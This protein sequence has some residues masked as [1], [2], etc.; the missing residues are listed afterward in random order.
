MAKEKNSSSK[1]ERKKCSEK[2]ETII[3]AVIVKEDGRQ[4]LVPQ[5]F[6]YNLGV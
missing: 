4:E 2:A 6:R 3:Y 1:E 5:E